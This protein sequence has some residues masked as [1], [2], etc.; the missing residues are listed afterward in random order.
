MQQGKHTSAADGGNGGRRLPILGWISGWGWREKIL[1]PIVV[2]VL[3]G[4]LLLILNPLGIDVREW[5]FP[6]KAAVSGR[7]LV[8]GQ[9]AAGARLMLDD[10]DAGNTAADGGFLI[11]SVGTGTHHLRVQLLGAHPTTKTFAIDNGET[12][13]ALGE[14]SMKPLFGLGY[15]VTPGSPHFNGTEFV[16][17]YDLYLWIDASAAALRGIKVVSYELPRPLPDTT[18]RRT[19]AARAFCYHQRGEL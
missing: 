10:T 13:L 3:G 18:V 15:V 11:S 16:A 6:T 4:L 9:G 2:A 1:V 5:L 17:A 7:V 8:G 14:I 19:A 12:K